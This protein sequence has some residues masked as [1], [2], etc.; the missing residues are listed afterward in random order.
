MKTNLQ[1]IRIHQEAFETIRWIGVDLNTTGHV[2]VL[3]EP[4]TGKVLKLGKNT[5]HVRSHMIKDCTK[6]YKEGKLWKL[7][8]F[9][10]RERKDFRATI[11]KISHQI[12]SFA[13]SVSSGIKFEKLFPKTHPPYRKIEGIYEF[14]FENGSFFTL[15]R[16]VEELAHIRGVP[17][18]YVD[19]TNTSKRCNRCGAFGRRMRKRFECPHCG[20]VAHADVNAAFNIATTPHSSDRIEL[21]RLRLDR[22]KIRILAEE[23][24]RPVHPIQ[25]PEFP[26]R[27][28]LLAVL[29]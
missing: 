13:E 20:N 4:E 11:H 10:N 17:V 1:V 8:R 2:A 14:S 28:N 15:Q 19:P 18:I 3:A 16:L 27:E 5:R 25:P 23:I 9:N 6:L 24:A 7:K 26:Y 21:D 12:V 22:K 29:Q